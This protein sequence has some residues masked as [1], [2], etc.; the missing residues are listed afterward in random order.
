MVLSYRAAPSEF[1]FEGAAV[2][3][4]SMSTTLEV[5]REKPLLFLSY[6][7]VPPVNT[8]W[9]TFDLSTPYFWGT[10]TDHENMIPPEEAYG[11]YVDGFIIGNN[12]SWPDFYFPAMDTLDRNRTYEFEFTFA[13]EHPDDEGERNVWLGALDD[14]DPIGAYN[15]G[16]V[17]W[18]ALWN[19]DH[20]PA[21]IVTITVPP[22]IWVTN[23]IPLTSNTL[24]IETARY[25]VVSQIR[26][27]QVA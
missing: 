21:D 1:D 2:Y 11:K 8:D 26:W 19:S 25:G 12:N 20:T 22:S 27:R 6:F 23:S 4:H 17:T 5:S 10:Y 24:F 14:A 13:P 7:G 15:G 18:N 16:S 3:S 9:H